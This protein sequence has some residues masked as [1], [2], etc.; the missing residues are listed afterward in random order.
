MGLAPVGSKPTISIVMR[1][2]S[3]EMQPIKI[4]NKI[5]ASETEDVDDEIF[6]LSDSRNKPESDLLRTSS[7]SSVEVS[8]PYSTVKINLKFV[9]TDNKF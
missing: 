3:S 8:G 7:R 4:K 5:M 6:Y 2:N 1:P 9:M